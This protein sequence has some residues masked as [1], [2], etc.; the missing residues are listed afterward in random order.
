MIIAY[1]T[2]VGLEMHIKDGKFNLMFKLKS[3]EVLLAKV[4]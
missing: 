1:S 2:I 3:R 4:G